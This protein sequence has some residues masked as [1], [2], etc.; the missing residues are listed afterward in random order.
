[1]YNYRLYN[2]YIIMLVIQFSDVKPA[3]TITVGFGGNY[4]IDPCR[5]ETVLSLHSALE[6]K[7][8]NTTCLLSGSCQHTIST[9]P[10]PNGERK[11]RSHSDLLALSITLTLDIEYEDLGSALQSLF[12]NKT[13]NV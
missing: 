13:G 7:L 9:S 8:Q 12:V 3:K 6:T 1:M 11:R 2:I 5:T 4:D 10:C